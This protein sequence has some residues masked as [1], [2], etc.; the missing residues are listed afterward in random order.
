MPSIDPPAV[1]AAKRFGLKL[2]LILFFA[3]AQIWTSWGFA[4]AF[5]M[6]ALGSAAMDVV[7]ALILR[8]R[9]RAGTLN[10]WDEAAIFILL[11]LAV[12]VWSQFSP[13]AA[14]AA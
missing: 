14:G 13:A 5:V 1:Y 6:L 11:A 9:P 2:L 3:A 12:A 10:Y 4:K 7:L 8:Q